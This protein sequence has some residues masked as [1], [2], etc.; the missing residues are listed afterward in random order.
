MVR[1]SQEIKK[2]L[3]KLRKMIK[4]RKD[5][6]KMR[7]FEKI[8]EKFL[9]NIRFCQFKFTKFLIFKSLRLVKNY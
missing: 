5:Q 1:K 9:K 6:V 3:E 7:V 8:Q 2:S 4:V